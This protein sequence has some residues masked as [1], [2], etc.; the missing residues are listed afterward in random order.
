MSINNL[1]QEKLTERL[2]AYIDGHLSSDEIAETKHWI[3]TNLEVKAQYLQLYEM[4]TALEENNVVIP[5][6][7]MIARYD[8]WLD[9]VQSKTKPQVITL[10]SWYKIA[11]AVLVIIVVGISSIVIHTVIKQKQE[12]ARVKAELESTKQLVITNLSNTQ[13]ASQRMSAVYST[14]DIAEPDHD[15]IQ[16]LIKT[17]DED[18]SSNVRMASLDALNKYYTIPEVRSAFIR[19]MKYQ[20]DPVVQ[21][22]L[23]QL[24]VQRKEKIIVDDLQAITAQNGIIKAVKDEAYKGIFKLT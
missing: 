8:Q 1:E 7:V 12:L 14:E 23:I 10:K 17:M 3:D 4:V 20:K 24:L 19:S 9:T 21:I 13:S 18:P 22:A 6:D 11:A 5:S 15:I 16:L 2:M